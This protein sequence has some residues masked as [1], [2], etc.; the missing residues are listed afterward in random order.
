MPQKEGRTNGISWKWSI[1][2]KKLPTLVL[3]HGLL[4]SQRNW[5]RLVK[6]LGDIRNI[7]TLDLRG[8]GESAHGGPYTIE[9][10]ST[11]LAAVLEELKIEKIDLLGHSFG[12][13][14]ALFFAGSH[15]EKLDK[16]IIEDTSDT[17]KEEA[18]EDLIKMLDDVQ[19][20]FTSKSHA[21]E[22]LKGTFSDQMLV[23]FLYTNL[24]EIAARKVDWIFDLAGMKEL[25]QEMVETPLTDH[26]K[27]IHAPTLLVRGEN[28]TH[29]S[30]ED[31]KN[32]GK[33][34]SNSQSTE[35]KNA[36]HWIHA[37][38]F[39]DFIGALEGFLA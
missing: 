7:L 19:P 3:V 11:D 34:L 4:G 23:E 15:P 20:P 24:K 27:K 36:G 26:L 30:S 5:G 6:S 25:I 29:L 22:V 18:K 37:E 12:G 38:N 8:H 35:I 33:A 39:K 28:S 1:T 21:R 16:L 32:M 14:V 31:F 13:R 17:L 9:Q 2:S 10:C